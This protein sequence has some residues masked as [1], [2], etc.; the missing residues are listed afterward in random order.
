MRLEQGTTDSRCGC[1]C[2]SPGFRKACRSRSRSHLPQSQLLPRTPRTCFEGPFGEVLRATGPMAKANPFRFSTKY[3]DDETDLLYY[4]YRYY[5]P[6]TGRWLSPDP[7]EECGGVN[8]HGFCANNAASFSD[9]NGLDFAIWCGAGPA[10]GNWTGQRQ[11]PL[12]PSMP[13][14]LWRSVYSWNLR[15]HPDTPPRNR[16]NDT[17]WY[18][19]NRPNAVAAAQ[20]YFKDQIAKQYLCSFFNF[21]LQPIDD[22][23]VGPQKGGKV[24]QSE[25]EL[26]DPQQST[27]ESMFWI[28]YFSFRLT[29]FSKVWWDCCRVKYDA[30][31]TL[32]DTYGIQEQHGSRLTPLLTVF[33][34]PQ[35]DISSGEWK[36]SGWVSCCPGVSAAPPPYKP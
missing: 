27:M 35:H 30:T 17:D 3:Q 26:G 13:F 36:V 18:N 10:Y 29:S 7:L 11:T 20:Q 33:V 9:R 4:G 25:W 32:I 2:A 1:S 34:G 16:W 8:V 6:S 24:G 22:Y 12:P 23:V 15:F 31:V 28:G 21:P 19:L 14:A 5:N